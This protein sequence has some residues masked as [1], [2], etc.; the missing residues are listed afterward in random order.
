VVMRC[1]GKHAHFAPGSVPGTES[2]EQIGPRNWIVFRKVVL[3]PN[4]LR[5]ESVLLFLFP[6]SAPVSRALVGRVVVKGC[7][8]TFCKR[9][10]KKIKTLSDS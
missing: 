10:R 1:C 2:E 5:P 6:P 9:A 3:F 4:T 8:V 7:L